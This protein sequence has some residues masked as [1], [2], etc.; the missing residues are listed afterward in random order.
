MCFRNVELYRAVMQMHGDIGKRALITEFGT[1][2]QTPLDLGPYEW[3]E[4]AAQSRADYL[5][6]AL[7][8]ASAQYTWLMG[9]TIFNLD[10]AAQTTLPQTSERRWFSLLNAD[11][12]PRQAYTRI[13]E[14]RASGYLPD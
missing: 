9:A 4:L 6:D 10:Y 8:M 12:S 1:L 14:A 13:K 11:R 2:E 3:M 5:V 7:H